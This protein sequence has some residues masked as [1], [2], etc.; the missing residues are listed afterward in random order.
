MILALAAFFALGWYAY[1]VL[2]ALAASTGGL[3]AGLLISNAAVR[4]S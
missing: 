1:G 2:N 3:A 4:R